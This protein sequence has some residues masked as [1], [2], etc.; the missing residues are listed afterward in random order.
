MR[1]SQS[2]WRV[3]WVAQDAARTGER[4]QVLPGWGDLSAIVCDHANL[5]N[6]WFQDSV[7]HNW[8]DG[9]KL[10]PQD[11]LSRAVR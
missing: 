9:R 11:W 8:R 5:P 10:I 7:V 2:M 3:F 1:E 4:R 6:Q